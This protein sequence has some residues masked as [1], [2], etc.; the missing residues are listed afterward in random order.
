MFWVSDGWHEEREQTCDTSVSPVPLGSSDVGAQSSPKRLEWEKMNLDTGAAVN[1]FPVNFSPEGMGDEG[2]YDWIP[3]GEA[4]QYQGYD[5]K[6]FAQ[7]SEWKTHRC[8]PSV[9]QCCR[10]RVQRTTRLHFETLLNEYGKNDLIPVY[11]ETNTFNVY[12]NREVKSAGTNKCEQ[13]RAVCCEEKSTV[14]KRVWQSSALVS[15]TTTL[16]RDVA[17]LG[18]DIE[19]MGESRCRCRNRKPRRR[20]ILGDRNSHS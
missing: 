10:D 15:P 13:C 5:E 18:D 8:T 11:L 14:G 4:W 12:L 7:I 6:S 20:R 3:D 1:T 17:P 19:P 2:F 16:S 9:V